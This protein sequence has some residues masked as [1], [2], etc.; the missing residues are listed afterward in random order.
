MVYVKGPTVIN[1]YHTFTIK[2]VNLLQFTSLT[3]DYRLAIE[4]PV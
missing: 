4:R 1:F 3:S 2:C